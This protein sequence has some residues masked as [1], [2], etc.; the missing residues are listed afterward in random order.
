MGY[1]K[2]LKLEYLKYRFKAK[3]ATTKLKI[4]ILKAKWL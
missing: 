1:P 2:F 4:G 3:R